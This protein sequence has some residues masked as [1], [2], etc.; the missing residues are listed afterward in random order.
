MHPG[1]EP[2]INIPGRRFVGLFLFLAVFFLPLH[3]H[4]AVAAP[5]VAKECSCF[6]GSRTDAGIAPLAALTLPVADY[7]LLEFFSQSEFFFHV[8][9]SNASRAPPSFTSI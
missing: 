2:L 9:G 8:A 7:W 6:H 4:V 5:H 3:L 1:R